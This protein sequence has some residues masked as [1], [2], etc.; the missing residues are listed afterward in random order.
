MEQDYAQHRPRMSDERCRPCEVGNHDLS[1]P[2][3][4]DDVA[5]CLCCGETFTLCGDHGA[6]EPTCDWCGR[7]QCS[8][9]WM[10]WDGETGNHKECDEREQ[11]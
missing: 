6:N 11:A 3:D 10:P 8:T 4:V 2:D 7:G 5:T 9:P 1:E